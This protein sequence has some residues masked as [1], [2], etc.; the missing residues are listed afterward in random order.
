VYSVVSEGRR[1]A[2]LTRDTLREGGKSSKGRQ[3]ESF[4]SPGCPPSVLST[5]GARQRVRV[6]PCP[7]PP[8]PPAPCPQ[9]CPQPCP[10]S[11]DGGGR[12][13]LE[14]VTPKKY[15]MSVHQQEGKQQ[16]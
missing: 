10:R 15:G 16:R 1:G 7:P 6:S 2:S 14:T 9:P 12:E 11:N 5:I 8:P 4:R 13:P 3:Y